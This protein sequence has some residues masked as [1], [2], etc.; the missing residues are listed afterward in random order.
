[1]ISLTISSRALKIDETKL[2]RYLAY[3][4]GELEEEPDENNPN[5]PHL[6]ATELSMLKKYRRVFEMFDMGRNDALIRSFLQKEYGVKERQARYIVEEAKILFGITGKSD[7]EGQKRASI[8][9]YRMASNIALADKNLEAFHKLR[10][11]ADILDGLYKDEEIGLDPEQ[12]MKPT[13]VIFTNNV[14]ILKQFK[15]LDGDE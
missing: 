4:W 7:A 11:E 14:N 2:D 9:A 15:P 8:A 10:K 12:F 5:A 3:Y 6:T 13:Q 1:M